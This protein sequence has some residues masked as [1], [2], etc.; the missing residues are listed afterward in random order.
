MPTQ[1]VPR[2][3]IGAARGLGAAV[4]PAAVGALAAAVIDLIAPRRCLGCGAA[5]PELCAAC[6]DGLR[7]LEGPLCPCCGSP[8]P[9]ARADD[10]GERCRECR[11]RTLAFATARAAVAYD[12]ALRG[13]VGAWKERGVRGAAPLAAGLVL[14]AVPRP[15]GAEAITWVPP[16]RDRALRRGDHPAERLARALGQ[17]WGL[18]AQ[19]LLARRAG[20][21]RQRGL[22]RSERQAN[23][24]GAFRALGM[25]PPPHALVLVDDVYTTGATVSAAAAALL[26]AGARRVDVVTLARAVR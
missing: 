9:R 18:P 5:G 4:A 14:G 8:R 25:G 15:R 6:V 7:L 17:G 26:A 20:S 11:T 2:R 19:P 3:G 16:D 1:T 23:V 24:L 10:A 21:R 12:D 22:G 13:F